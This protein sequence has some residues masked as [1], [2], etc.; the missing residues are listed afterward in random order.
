MATRSLF[1]VG[2]LGNSIT[3]TFEAQ[4]RRLRGWTTHSVYVDRNRRPIRTVMAALWKTDLANAFLVMKGLI[5]PV[6][7]ATDLSQLKLSAA[8]FREAI[9][10]PEGAV[11]LVCGCDK[12]IADDL[13]A[14]GE[15]VNFHNSLLP[16]HAGVSAVG[17]TLLQQT[18]AGWTFHR[19]TSEFDS[20]EILMQGRVSYDCSETGYS[21]SNRVTK[22]AAN[23]LAKLLVILSGRTSPVKVGT[24]GRGSYHSKA[25]TK[26]VLCVDNDPHEIIARKIIA[27][28]NVGATVSG[29]F[30]IIKGARFANSTP[31]EKVL[32]AIGLLGHHKT[33]NG[34]QLL[35]PMIRNPWAWR[36]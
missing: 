9:Q 25:E 30:R 14:G 10:I 34:E 29:S 13:L 1:L 21:V 7:R 16:V 33:T 8:T 32:V 11:F 2:T 20:G 4:A 23:E 22:A 3:H 31:V 28:G 24:G 27:F 26:A 5:L 6:R 18:E 12:R 17:W 15:W 19:M 35:F 36:K